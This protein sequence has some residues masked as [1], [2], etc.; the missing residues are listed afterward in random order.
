M[1]E[2]LPPVFERAFTTSTIVYAG[3]AFV[4]SLEMV[5]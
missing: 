1:Q 5:R 2:H 4:A 3:D